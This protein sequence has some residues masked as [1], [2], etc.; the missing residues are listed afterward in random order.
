M[1]AAPLCRALTHPATAGVLLIT[2]SL[3]AII[4]ASS[5]S[6]LYQSI[7]YFPSGEAETHSHL[8]VLTVINDGLMAVFFL[9]AG[10]EIKYDMNCYRARSTAAGEQYSPLSPL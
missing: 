2:A 1:L 3:I 8:T 5:S 10:L 4:M 7:I 9:A 6:T